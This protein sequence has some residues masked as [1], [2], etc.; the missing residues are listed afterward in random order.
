MHKNKFSIGDLV[1]YTEE[2]PFA[3]NRNNVGVVV[4]ILSFKQEWK[5]LEEERSPEYAKGFLEELRMYHALRTVETKPETYPWDRQQLL[6]KMLL[7]DEEDCTPLSETYLIKV[8]WTNG[9][10]YIEHPADLQIVLRIKEVPDGT[11]ENV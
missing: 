2:L 6:E 4:E 9:E 7:W 3:K 8:V 5:R 10:T 11:S 1:E